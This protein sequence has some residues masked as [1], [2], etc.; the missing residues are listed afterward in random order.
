MRR[1]KKKKAKERKEKY[2]RTLIVSSYQVDEQSRIFPDV[3]EESIRGPAA[4]S[5]NK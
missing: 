3:D 4:A 1:S 5:L 2:M